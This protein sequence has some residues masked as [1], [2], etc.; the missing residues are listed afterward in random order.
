MNALKEFFVGTEWS[1]YICVY[2]FIYSTMYSVLHVHWRMVPQSAYYI[3][4]SQ[5][6][7]IKILNWMDMRDTQHINIIGC[8]CPPCVD[9][10]NH[11]YLW[12]PLADLGIYLVG[13][14]GGLHVQPSEVRKGQQTTVA[15]GTVGK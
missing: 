3:L 9:C 4:G 15:W 13:H 6:H 12:G 10:P 11:D 7:D 14:H 2:R 8:I 5:E 1:V